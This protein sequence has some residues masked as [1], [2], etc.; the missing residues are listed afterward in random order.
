[1]FGQTNVLLII[2]LFTGA[3]HGSSVQQK[4][5]HLHGPLAT[6]QASTSVQYDHVLKIFLT[7]M[8]VE[9]HCSPAGVK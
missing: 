1:M 7:V 8:K 3:E 9:D 2:K 4:Q 5:H 6:L